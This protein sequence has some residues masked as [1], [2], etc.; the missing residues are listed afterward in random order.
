MVDLV[1]K[2]PCE[3]LLPVSIGLCALAE[4]TPPSITSIAPQ[5][6]QENQVSMALKTAHGIGFP[7]PNRATGKEGARCIW[8]GQGQ[9]FLVGPQPGV[10]KNAALSDQSDGWAVMRLSGADSETVL[11]RLVPVDLGSTSFKRGH[12]VRT[13][14]N[15]MAASITRTGSNV[16]DIM[17][18]RSMAL[19]AIHELNTAMKS[20]AAQK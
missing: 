1:A 6:G 11:A 17:V 3:S 13:L 9:A 4:L 7:R 2:P 5:K 10:I 8:T 16:F 20:V 14:I 18:F 12:C 15:H 19:T